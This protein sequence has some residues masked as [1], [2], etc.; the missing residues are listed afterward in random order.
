MA[1]HF[2]GAA[3]VP[4]ELKLD[5]F[6][7][8]YEAGGAAV[9]RLV[10]NGAQIYQKPEL[11]VGVELCQIHVLCFVFCL[12][13]EAVDLLPN[14]LPFDTVVVGRATHRD[15]DFCQF[16]ADLLNESLVPAV[17]GSTKRRSMPFMDLLWRLTWRLILVSV[18]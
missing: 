8:V 12:P 7:D 15:A 14:V 1:V 3:G 18:H 4:L 13:E 17:Y 9:Y 5:P 11:V 6:F 10:R 16:R 2:P